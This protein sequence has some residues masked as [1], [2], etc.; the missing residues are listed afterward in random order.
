M[1]RPWAR[2]EYLKSVMHHFVEK[3]KSLAK[4]I[5]YSDGI[6]DMFCRNRR[7]CYED[8]QISAR[9]RDFAYAPHRYNSEAKVL[10]RLVLTLDASLTTAVQVSLG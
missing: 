3:H 2:D 7:T 8:I 6:K 1:S 10:S 5:C 4:I 9:I